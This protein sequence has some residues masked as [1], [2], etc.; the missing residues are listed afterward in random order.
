MSQCEFGVTYLSGMYVT[1]CSYGQIHW[2]KKINSTKN[3][4]NWFRSSDLWVAYETV[5][6]VWAHHSSSELWS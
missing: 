4:S 5:Y 2:I 6:L 3:S 1:L